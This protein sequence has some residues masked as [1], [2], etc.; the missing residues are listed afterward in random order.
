MNITKAEMLRFVD[1]MEEIAINAYL[2]NYK[3][4]TIVDQFEVI[5]ANIN[6]WEEDGSCQSHKKIIFFN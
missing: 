6:S 4:K 1:T 3:L 5:R 2:R